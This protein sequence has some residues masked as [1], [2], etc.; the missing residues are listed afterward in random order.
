ML[1]KNIS[2]FFLFNLFLLMINT[3]VFSQQHQ[4]LID[5]FQI[6]E[7]SGWCNHYEP[8]IAMNA[9]G[10][11]IIVWHDYK[12][13]HADVYLQRFNNNLDRIG[14]DILVNDDE[15]MNHQIKPDVA[16]DVSGRFVVT[17]KD[18]RSGKD[19]IYAQRFDS[20]AN[21]LGNN[22]NVNKGLG[23]L[24]EYSFPSIA[25]SHDGNFVIT[26]LEKRDS[27]F[28]LYSQL[29]NN[30]GEQIKNIFKVND[31]SNSIDQYVIPD[32]G[33]DNSGNFVIVWED[34]RQNTNRDIFAQRF[35]TDGNSIS[36]N[37]KV[38]DDNNTRFHGNPSVSVFSNGNFVIT[39][40]DERNYFYDIYAQ[41]FDNSGTPIA[42][43][44]IVNDVDGG[45]QFTPIVCT[46]SSGKFVI[47]W[48]DEREGSF[49]IF[50]QIYD[51][52]G[53]SI[54]TNRKIHDDENSMYYLTPPASD[55]DSSGNFIITW[56]DKH[57][58]NNQIYAGKFDVEG[59]CVD[60]TFQ[61]NSDIGS[62]DQYDPKIC[63]TDNGNIVIVWKDY[64]NGNSDIY[65]QNI[66]PDGSLSDENYKV[67]EANDSSLQLN[68]QLGI[69]SEGNFLVVWEEERKY[70]NNIY[71]QRF[72][73]NGQPSGNNFIINDR[74]SVNLRSRFPKLAMNQSGDC[75]ISWIESNEFG[76]FNL[77]AKR[78]NSDGMALENS[79][80]VNG[81]TGFLAG[82]DFLYGNQFSVG[83]DDF[84]NFVISW[85]E[86]RNGLKEVFYK[87]YNPNGTILKIAT[88]VNFDDYF[89]VGDHSMCMGSNGYFVIS[90]VNWKN[91]GYDNIYAQLYNSL[92][93][94]IGNNI[95]V[96]DVPGSIYRF[97][98]PTLSMNDDGSFC[99]AWQDNRNGNYDIYG[100][101]YSSGGQLIDTNF[102]INSNELMPDQKTPSLYLKENRLYTA[103]E[104]NRIPRQG[105]DIFAN[106]I[107]LENVTSVDKPNFEKNP[108]SFSLFQNYPNP[109]NPS[110][111][112]K[113]EI[114][115]RARNDI[116]H[117]QLQM[118]DVLGRMV[119][120]LVDKQQKPGN[121]EVIFDANN[122]TS[123]IY[124]YKL[125]A[126]TFSESKKMI[127]LK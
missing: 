11:F 15:G 44:F 54:G 66:K 56:N 103:W 7:N 68:P 14:D 49:D 94:P 51:E 38:N 64:R 63:A 2:V 57:T 31:Q 41:R 87:I 43:N 100:Q 74:E 123:G 82:L 52:D 79:F 26:W 127:L 9:D 67:N 109:F 116:V 118:Y 29:Y 13:T 61:V 33:M 46:S 60:S 98:P 18:N 62:G 78:F 45:Q 85:T 24:T 27:E 102:K 55:M 124:F 39:W 91:E 71:G 5:D 32:A 121:Y 126:G 28:G 81:N 19:E 34:L 25:I 58:G 4:L 96:N 17:W 115:G 90:W 36:Q 76:E 120:T 125:K 114:P 89:S 122:L 65:V 99:I 104:D 110:T 75:I 95:L 22:F 50:S 86:Y 16:I 10:S 47:T 117:V 23:D 69:D 30:N 84:N 111:T 42:S 20:F 107:F 72:N 92:G 1:F 97:L 6:N 77:Y 53:T 101:V 106:A 88:R 59:D 21:P 113:Y 73:G 70:S 80:K 48:K 37:F 119:A 3:L 112:V 35:D 8:K 105:W 108:Y 40:I 83:I 12:N 93:N